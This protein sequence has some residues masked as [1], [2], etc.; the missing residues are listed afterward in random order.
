MQIPFL[1]GSA[2]HKLIF[3][4]HRFP[5]NPGGQ[6]QLKSATKSVQ[7]ALRRQGFSA[8]SSVLTSHFCPSQPGKHSHL[9]RPCCKAMQ[10]APLMQGF[11]LALHGSI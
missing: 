8:Q 10:V 5:V 1:H 11:P 7:F 6:E 2:E 3:S 4:W 9:K